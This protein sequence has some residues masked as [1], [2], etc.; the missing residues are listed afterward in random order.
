V[1]VRS[2][3]RF[4][5]L[6]LPTVAAVAPAHAAGFEGPALIA[7]V[8]E[9]NQDTPRFLHGNGC[10]NQPSRMPSD[11]AEY[12]EPPVLTSLATG[13]YLVSVPNGAPFPAGD[14]ETGFLSFVTAF[15]GN[16]Q[17]FEEGT[18][19]SGTT[20][21]SNVRCVDPTGSDVDSEFSWSYRADSL[22]YPQGVAHRPNFAYARVEPSGALVAAESFNPLDLHDDDIVVTKNSGAGDYTIVFRDLNPLDG[23]LNP[24][25]A[26]YNVVVQKTCAGDGTGGDADD[27]CYRTV[28]VPSSWTPG[29]FE[30]W[31][32][33][34]NVRC[35]DASGA[36]R[37]TG[38]RVFFGDEGHNSQGS[39]EGG[40][41]YAW[42]NWSLDPSEPGCHR[43]P[44]ILS[45]GQHES[46]LAFPGKP[47]EAC[48]ESTGSYQVN[49]VDESH[50][51]Y[52]VDGPS[53]AVASR[54]EDG[55]HCNVS[56]FTCPE[57]GGA[58]GIENTSPT[59]RVVVTCFAPNGDP[60]DARWT[61]NLTY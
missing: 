23:A 5:V 12:C 10:L 42:A 34:V 61:M 13:R 26:P 17:C 18:M 8:P 29:D 9:Y 40:L 21:E 41:H 53:F 27:G 44:E 38:F 3:L 48:R 43:P 60:A 36:P 19:A 56:S 7:W 45:N 58:C 30:T 16:A 39:W 33:S 51:A 37:D 20:L 14:D 6:V 28:C 15:R 2:T 57:N 25:L 47:I 59:T 32:T 22:E 1:P 11:R 55:T 49:Y 52:S 24:L 54:A 46:P 35:F 50:S 31:D 4:W